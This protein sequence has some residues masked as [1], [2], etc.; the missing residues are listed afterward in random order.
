[1]LKKIFPLPVKFL[2]GFIY[3]QENIYEKTKNVLVKKF[4]KIDIESETINFN[5]T[6]YYSEEMGG[7]LFRRFI[8]FEKL[9]NPSDFISIKCFCVNIE[10]KT[11][12]NGKRKINIDPGYINEA[13]L[14]LTTTKDFSHRIYLGKGIYAEVTLQYRNNRFV[15]SAATF[16]DYRTLE[17]KNIFLKIRDTYR[18]QIHKK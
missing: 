4:G 14:V 1:M 2:C 7:N 11:A 13:K 8:S 16:P 3:P 18:Q 15:E 5:F 6:D 9:R 17:Y 12:V 10:K